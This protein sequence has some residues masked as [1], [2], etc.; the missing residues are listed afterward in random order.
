MIDG[1]IAGLRAN[2]HELTS[3][4]TLRGCAGS[5]WSCSFGHV[6]D[7]AWR[8]ENAEHWQG[9]LRKIR[10]C[11]CLKAWVVMRG[12]EFYGF[13]ALKLRQWSLESHAFR[14]NIGPLFMKA[15]VWRWGTSDS[16]SP[17]PTSRLFYWHH[18]AAGGRPTAC[19]SCTYP[20]W[21]GQN[22]WMSLQQ[23]AKIK[24]QMSQMAHQG[25]DF[26]DGIRWRFVFVPQQLVFLFA[27]RKVEALTMPWVLCEMPAT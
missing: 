10:N 12:N 15:G 18:F 27:S 22:V 4:G 21:F 6:S 25:A 11:S 7:K 9:L 23:H 14:W 13:V 2:H 26:C 19:L 1:S 5:F 3:R 20:S 8:E 17:G 24:G 16:R